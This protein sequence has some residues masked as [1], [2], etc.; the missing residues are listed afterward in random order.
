M[1]YETIPTL[2]ENTTM[3]KYISASGKFLAYRITPVAG[4]VLHDNAGNFT[5]TNDVEQDAY[6]YGTCS[7]GANYEFTPN[8]ITV[9]DCNGNPMTVTAYGTREFFAI[10]E[11][12][13]PENN[14]FG[15]GDNDHEIM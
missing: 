5:D 9:T 15:G 4:Y 10:P 12:T 6:F 7:C 14:I 1:A 3:Q 8:T 13:A 2:I 11:S